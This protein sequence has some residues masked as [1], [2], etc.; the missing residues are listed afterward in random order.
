MK[1]YIILILIITSIYFICPSISLAAQ[2]GDL[3]K[4]TCT[5]SNQAICKTVYYLGA[6]NK[7]YSFPNQK[8]YNTWYDDF[9]NVQN[10]SQAEMASYPIGGNV[11]YKPGV[12]MVKITT[13]PKTYVVA[14]GGVLRWV[15]S[16]QAAKALYGDT[17]IYSIDDIPDVFF[18]NYTIGDPV[19]S[20]SDYDPETVR[21]SLLTINQN[22]GLTALPAPEKS[23]PSPQPEP[24]TTCT[25]NSSPVFTHDITDFYRIGQITPPGSV[26]NGHFKA[27]SY[28]WIANGL[29]VPVYAPVDMTLKNG[30]YYT[31]QGMTQYVLSFQVSCEVNIKLDHILNPI[32]TVRD[33]FPDTA[34]PTNDTRG[35]APTNE[36]SFKAGDLIGNTSGTLEA[37]NW[38][39]GV[40]NSVTGGQE[41][42]VCPYDYFETNKKSAYYGLFI[43]DG[44]RIFCDY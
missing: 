37:H 36:I 9:L 2:S 21:D 25:S 27:H 18:I 12:R 35:E 22:K 14:Q 4:I 38:D 34:R 6:D 26:I 43:S 17:W 42:G 29:S 31:E 3:I 24:Q 28:I 1:K 7:R 5:S 11:T 8:V 20:H 10:I 16:E 23:E 19:E 41:N 39:F 40:Y 13:D 32:Q 15:K 33:V 44:S 30:A